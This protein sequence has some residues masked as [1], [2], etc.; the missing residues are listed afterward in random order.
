[1]T[2]KVLQ[3][4]PPT[5]VFKNMMMALALLLFGFV[6]Q[7]R[8][9]VSITSSSAVTENFSS[10][11]PPADGTA[12]TTGNSPA[13][14]TL[15]ATGNTWRANQTTNTAGGWYSSNNLSFL[16]SGSASNAQG[17]WILQNN[18]GTTITGF[19][20]AYTARMWKSGANSPAGTVSWSNNA[21][22]TN[23]T[24]GALS[25]SLSSLNFNDGVSG[26]AT[27]TT[28]SQTVSSLSIANGQFI[29]IRF[30]HPG[31][32]SSDNLGW[33]DV[34]F[35]PTL[36]AGTPTKLAITSVSPASPTR[37]S[38]F[39]V[40]VQSQDGSSVAQN[41]TSNTTVNLSKTIGT[42][43]LSGTLTGTINSGSNSVTF[44]G[45]TYNVAETG[46]Q[47]TAADGAAAL[48]SGTTTFNVLAAASQLAFVSVP[49]SG[50]VNAVL[51]SFT[52]EAR[53]P[54]N[55]VDNTYTGNITITKATGPGALSGTTTV[56]AVA[57]VATFSTLQF[58]QAGSYTLS[59]ASGSLAPA[60][61]G[62]IS[63]T[64]AP[65][66]W[67]FGTGSGTAAPTSGTPVT[68]LT[69][70]NVLQ[71]N[72]NGT[73]TMLDATSASSGYTG[74]SGNF[75]A[76]A[77]ARVGAI[78]T[79]ASG[80]AYFEFTLTPATGYVVT[81]SSI[82]FGSRS[83]GT[84]PA[85]FSVRSSLDGYVANV[86]TGTLSTASTWAL[87]SPSTTA[88]TSLAGTAITF[89]IFGHGG[90]GSPGA[91]TANWRIDDLNIAVDVTCTAPAITSVTS[92]SPFC[93]GQNLALSAVATGTGPLS[94]QWSGT[95][96]IS[97]N[98][99]AAAN[100]TTV[101]GASAGTYT[102]TVT[103]A[104]G[105]TT[106][107]TSVTTNSAPTVS[108]PGNQTA[109]NTAGLCSAVVTYS[110]PST[111]TPAPAITY[112]FSGNTTGSGS[113]NG[114]GSAFNV[115][116]TTVTVTATNTCGSQSCSFDVVVN[117]TE[118]PV[119]TVA[120]IN[121]TVECDGAGNTADLND[122]LI[123][124]WGDADA[125]DNCTSAALL[126]TYWE[127]TPY[128]WTAA[129]GNTGTTG[130]VG[131]R[132]R[133][134][135]NNYSAYT[136]ATFTIVD[137]QAPSIT[138]TPPTANLV[139][140]AGLCTSSGSIGA[141]TA[142]DVCSGAVTP[143][144]SPA[145]P[146]AVG[147]HT[148]TWTATDACGNSSTSTQ[149]VI[150]TD[151]QNPVITGCPSNLN[152]NTDPGQCN[153][154]VV[155]TAP[156]A[157]DN[158]S[159][160]S[161]TSNHNSGDTFP[162]GQTTVTYTATDVNGNTATCSFVVTVTDNQNPVIT[163]PA[164]ANLTADAGL[165]TSSASIG[166]ATATDN[167]SVS[168]VVASP[169]GP[170]AVGTTTVTWTATDVNGNTATCNQTVNVSDTENPVIANCP[171]NITVSNDAG[172]CGAVVNYIAPTATD[173]CAGA[174]INGNHNSGDTFP[175]GTTTVTYYS[176]RCKQQYNYLLI[177]GNSKQYFACS[178]HI[179][180]NQCAF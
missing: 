107:S 77:A 63:I 148:I 36:L 135:S 98:N 129:C 39:S 109:S 8:A 165:C 75:N 130:L 174:T 178:S 112:S 52:V 111:G 24:A 34:T 87:S 47:L 23:P 172:T 167:C 108:C 7:G 17:T 11:T 30:I 106:G 117:D 180:N 1:M 61:S 44:S 156:T 123:T 35:T 49:S 48:T 94:Y 166:T 176:Y 163:C 179:S 54:D 84:G 124:N 132:V 82:T 138:F 128:T 9:Q 146:Y 125:T 57:G 170:Y 66:V 153:A 159:I 88:T 4:T 144:A 40:T 133:D 12:I 18:T 99:S 78:N 151:N 140:D 50:F 69:I 56:A 149:T 37:N 89:R 46:V 68:N 13:N 72:N 136:Y 14:W 62:T 102:V 143:V 137:T 55:S 93:T 64:Q 122:W 154:V 71:G 29:F 115:G 92:N 38:A 169:A 168:S 120:A 103:N 86:A 113:G 19:T 26:I 83:T 171:S 157:S 58:N 131:F 91:N 134:R 147:T 3:K 51:T 53:R 74:A 41:V 126:D 31:G 152:W 85:A 101:T 104:C 142:T 114:S 10:F 76:A 119:I 70:G 42:G 80:S 95:G 161:F 32:S 27:G 141:A 175:I 155:W 81:L 6:Q 162:I 60:T 16:G 158:C 164:T 28:L 21:S 121:R 177:Y 105:T 5:Q 20:L 139:A 118:V 79:A 127:Y 65:V 150:V 116:T 160:Q 33:D 45:L 15:T 43:T 2:N 173:N 22:S 96:T 97:P 90:A 145:G 100:N 25:N 67:N 110:T 59:A 73:T